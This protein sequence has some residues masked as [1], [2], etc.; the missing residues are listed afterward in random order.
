ML[1]YLCGNRKGFN[2][3]YALTSLIER[4][5]KSLD[6]KGYGGSVLMDLSKAFDNLN[7]NLLIAKIHAYGF[8]I[9]TLKLLHSYLVK[10]WQKTKV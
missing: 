3:Q 1:P 2:S 9:R 7:Y 8:D 6:N 10:R 4:W 5:H